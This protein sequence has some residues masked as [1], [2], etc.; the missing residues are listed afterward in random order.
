MFG[1]FKSK[2]DKEAERIVSVLKENKEPMFIDGNVVYELSLMIRNRYKLTASTIR[3]IN[4]GGLLQA[5]KDSGF[6][7]IAVSKRETLYIQ[8]DEE[9]YHTRV[10]IGSSTQKMLD[11]LKNKLKEYIKKDVI[12]Y[13]GRHI[14]TNIGVLIG[15]ITALGYEVGIAET[16]DENNFPFYYKKHKFLL[17]A[18]DDDSW[19]TYHSI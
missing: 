10:S 7:V 14:D 1:L 6:V 2:E 12:G 16:E 5:R 3:A 15:A 11:E 13:G 9:E 19:V 4:T 18:A 8:Y 17:T